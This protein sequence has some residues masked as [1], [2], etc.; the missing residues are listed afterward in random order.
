MAGLL[1]KALGLLA[2][3][4]REL[5]KRMKETRQ[6]PARVVIAKINK[7][8]LNSIDATY[9]MKSEYERLVF[10]LMEQNYMQSAKMHWYQWPLLVRL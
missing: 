8:N 9:S 6:G 7:A 3:D 1:S 4:G 10:R 2:T 5:F